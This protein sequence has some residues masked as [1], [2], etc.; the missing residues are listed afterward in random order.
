MSSASADHIAKNPASIEVWM[1]LEPSLKKKMA[2]STEHIG[3]TGET[4][5]AQAYY[6]F[7]TLADC[8]QG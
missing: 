5:T 4:K 2:V 7:T 3:L 8:C 6:F 1:A